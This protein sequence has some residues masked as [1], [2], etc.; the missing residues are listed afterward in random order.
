VGG[1]LRLKVLSIIVT[2]AAPAV[3]ANA[4][5]VSKGK[6]VCEKIS[7]VVSVVRKVAVDDRRGP[8]T[9]ADGLIA[10]NGPTNSSA[11]AACQQLA[12]LLRLCIK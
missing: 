8:P 6:L 5:V 4:T 7:D 1:T 3:S 10:A 2:A 11:T 12:D 9:G